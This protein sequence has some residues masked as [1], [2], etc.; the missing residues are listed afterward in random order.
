M[1]NKILQGERIVGESG[2]EYCF[3]DGES[4][5]ING[6]EDSFQGWNIKF[7]DNMWNI[8]GETRLTWNINGIKCFSWN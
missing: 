8:S 4:P 7:E 6:V 3:H 2:V 1:E 5:G